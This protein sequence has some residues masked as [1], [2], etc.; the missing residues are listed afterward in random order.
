MTDYELAHPHDLLVRRFLI[1]P[2]LMADLMTYYVKQAA[3]QKIVQL[4]EL[5]NLRC[6][7]PVNIDKNL[8]EAIGDLR[9]STNFKASQQ[10]S[11][12]FLLFEHQSKIDK[13]I[14]MRGLQYIV[15][16]Y[17]RFEE[18]TG[19]KSKYPYPIVVVFYHGKIP[20]KELLEMD[21][22]IERVPGAEGN[23]LRYTLILIDMS[24]IPKNELKG[25]PALQALIETLQLASQGK[26]IAEFEHVA[27]HFIALKHDPRAKG[28][29]HSLVRY[30]LAVGKVSKELVIKA[31]STLLDEKEAEKMAMST[32][33]EL[34]LQGKAE[35]KAEAIATVLKVRFGVLPRH[36]VKSINSYS[37][38]IALESWTELAATCKSLDEFADALN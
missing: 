19:G 15:Q 5:A 28:W 8:I 10:Q 3:D 38:P 22:M 6:E 12:V 25:H 37:D 18:E 32:M 35:G 30:V 24:I 14:R 4:I 27:D 11:N 17:E 20:W 1:E 33:Q 13:H 34:M 21:E 2:E 9:F 7:S 16:A 26:L 36:I 23:L 29:L 31:F